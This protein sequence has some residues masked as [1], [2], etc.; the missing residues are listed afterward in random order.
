VEAGEAAG[1]FFPDEPAPGV[2]ASSSSA[3]LRIF[4]GTFSPWWPVVWI[5]SSGFFVD[6]ENLL[7][8]FFPS[9]INDEEDGEEIMAEFLD[10]LLEG[11][12]VLASSPSLVLC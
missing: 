4:F 1:F 6:I 2:V 7:R 9:L 10:A 5:E 8:D 12:V 3:E 11:D